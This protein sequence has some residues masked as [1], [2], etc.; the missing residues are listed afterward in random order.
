[1]KLSNLP[2]TVI[3]EKLRVSCKRPRK[4]ESTNLPS[5]KMK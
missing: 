4:N 3:N 5:K 2:K 1:M